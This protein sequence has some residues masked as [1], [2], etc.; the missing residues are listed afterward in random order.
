MNRIKSSKLKKTCLE[1]GRAGESVYT[2]SEHTRY[3]HVSLKKI[4]V[5]FDSKLANCRH[6]FS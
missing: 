6:H 5:M 1:V 4:R 3:G 2:P